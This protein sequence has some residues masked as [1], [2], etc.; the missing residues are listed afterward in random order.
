VTGG[1]TWMVWAPGRV[2]SVAHLAVL[3]NQPDKRRAVNG[4][5]SW[6]RVVKAGADRMVVVLPAPFGPSSA[7]T[8]P[9]GTGGPRRARR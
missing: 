5:R 2:R 7:T 8:W 3:T 9:A 4:Y 1:Q 6:H